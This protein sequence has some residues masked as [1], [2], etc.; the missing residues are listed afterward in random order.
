MSRYLMFGVVA[1][2]LGASAIWASSLSFAEPAA[3]V[4]APLMDEAPRPHLE[5]A[6][7]AAA[8]ASGACKASSSM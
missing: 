2:T 3:P 8:A 1:A 5:T 7:V 6:V 4:P